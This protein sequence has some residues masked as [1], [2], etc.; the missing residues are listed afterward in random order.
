MKTWKKLL[1]FTLALIMLMSVAALPAMA[2]TVEPEHEHTE[3][4]QPRV[5]YVECIYCSGSAKLVQEKYDGVHDLYQ[6]LK[7]GKTFLY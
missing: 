6:C 1:T 5:P 4:V 3:E 2:A 7:C